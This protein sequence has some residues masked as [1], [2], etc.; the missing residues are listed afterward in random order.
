MSRMV[1]QDAYSDDGGKTWYWFSNNSPCPLHACKDQN[2]P[3][4][5]EAQR[6]AIE[7]HQ[8]KFLAE[9]RQRMA[10]HVPG[11]EEMAQMRAAFG[12]GKVVRNVITGQEYRT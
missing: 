4:D 2:I 12:P 8:D 3:C 11:F 1:Y 6:A 10:N 9:Y 7:V 5:V